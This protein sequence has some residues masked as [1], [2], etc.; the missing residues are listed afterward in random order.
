MP[1]LIAPAMCRNKLASTLQVYQLSLCLCECSLK[2]LNLSMALGT[3]LQLPNTPMADTNM[4]IRI[5]TEQSPV[6][7]LNLQLPRGMSIQRLR[8]EI[9]C[10]HPDKP[11][12]ERQALSL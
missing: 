5:I 11:A 8:Q 10:R 3:I 2:P 7:R 4:A 1:F 12:V 9:Q 6:L